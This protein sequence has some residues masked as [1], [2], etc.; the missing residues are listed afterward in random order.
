MVRFYCGFC[1]SS[2][3]NFKLMVDH[4]NDK[5]RGKLKRYRIRNPV[6]KQTALVYA[7]KPEEGCQGLGW[8][9][10]ECTIDEVPK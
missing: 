9:P 2:F 6:L 5:H 3:P 4:Y 1:P 10:K 8:N 7:S